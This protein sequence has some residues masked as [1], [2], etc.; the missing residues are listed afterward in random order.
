VYLHK[1]KV[2]VDAW[3]LSD[4]RAEAAHAVKAATSTSA[5]AA[6]A[7][8]ARS[9]AVTATADNG[10]DDDTAA[11]A[12]LPA[13][14]PPVVGEEEEQKKKKKKKR[15]LKRVVTKRAVLEAL[16]DV[17]RER[18]RQERQEQERGLLEK[19]DGEDEE[20]GAKVVA[21]PPKVKKALKKKAVVFLRDQGR[22]VLNSKEA[23][24]AVAKECRD[25]QSRVRKFD[26]IL[27]ARN[28]GGGLNPFFFSVGDFCEHNLMSSSPTSRTCCCLLNLT[29]NPHFVCIYVLRSRWRV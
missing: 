6:A 23:L 21:A 12:T 11:A 29:R 26:R 27:K 8:H 14:V 19:E 7:T 9:D 3:T 2:N 4:V 24:L 28:E 25:P 1:Q 5:L 18:D 13:D 10:D 22:Q 17:L 16:F 15:D 20:V